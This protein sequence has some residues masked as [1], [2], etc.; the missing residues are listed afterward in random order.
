M[1]EI[2]SVTRPLSEI[3]RRILTADLKRSERRLRSFSKRLI[4]AGI[5]IC[6]TLWALT[7]VATNGRGWLP[8]TAFWLGLAVV[9]YV[10]NYFSEKPKYTAVVRRFEDALRRN[11][12]HEIRIQSNAFAELEEIEDEGAC[13]AFQLDDHR[14]VFVSGQDYYPSARFPN[15]DF[16]VIRVFDSQKSLVQE[17]VEKRGSKLKSKRRISAKAK[18]KLEVPEH[19]QVIEGDLDELETLLAHSSQAHKLLSS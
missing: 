10:W 5:I 12:V 14:I 15:S 19:L 2:D 9:M 11:E 6:G 16:S 13:F 1:P 7:M 4:S 18:S 3:E 17:F 8:A